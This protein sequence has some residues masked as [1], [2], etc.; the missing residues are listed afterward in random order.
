MIFIIQ[1]QL[2]GKQKLLSNYLAQLAKIFFAWRQQS[3][4]PKRAFERGV[5]HAPGGPSET[6]FA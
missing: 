3:G 4:Q 1:E 2:L 5:W 6:V